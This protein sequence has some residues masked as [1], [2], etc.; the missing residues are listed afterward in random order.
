VLESVGGAVFTAAIE[1]LA[2]GGVCVTFGASANRTVTFEVGNFFRNGPH[3]LYGMYLFE[4]FRSN[5]ASA[6]LST[7]AT[8]VAEER[9]RPHIAVEGS[10]TQIGEIAQ[11]LIDRRYPGKAVLRVE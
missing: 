7:L 2:R 3:T 9:L 4:E 8:M 10:W 11:Q 6:G 1:S 5:P